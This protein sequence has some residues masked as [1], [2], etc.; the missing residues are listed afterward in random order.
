MEVGDQHGFDYREGGATSGPGVC[1]PSEGR[2]AERAREF[3]PSLRDSVDLDSLSRH[4]R[5]GL[6][7][8][9]ASRLVSPSATGAHISISPVYWE[10]LVWIS[11]GASRMGRCSVLTTAFRMWTLLPVQS[12]E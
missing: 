7:H 11:G 3:V 9:A 2:G 6:S 8:A 5:A 1:V 4:F 12:V 10:M